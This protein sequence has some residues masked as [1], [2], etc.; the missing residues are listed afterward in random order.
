MADQDPITLSTA[1]CSRFFTGYPRAFRKQNDTV[2][3]A[4]RKRLRPQLRPH[5]CP[6][7]GPNHCR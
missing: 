3:D 7:K 4:P 2:A 5:L 6:W 1:V